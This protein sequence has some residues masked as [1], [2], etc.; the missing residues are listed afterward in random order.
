MKAYFGEPARHLVGWSGRLLYAQLI[1]SGVLFPLEALAA[2]LASAAVVPH[3]LRI[4]KWLP[5]CHK[6]C[7]ALTETSL[8]WRLLT[9]DTV[10]RRDPLVGCVSS[11]K[12]CTPPRGSSKASITSFKVEDLS[13]F[14]TGVRKGFVFDAH[15]AAKVSGLCC[16][17]R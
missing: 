4:R 15:H 2:S 17:R 8:T 12:P 16:W 5:A 14:Y 10:D 1:W 3:Q 9:E 7:E 13:L 11:S 6:V